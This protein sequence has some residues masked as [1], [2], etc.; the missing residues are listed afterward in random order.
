MKKRTEKQSGKPRV[1]TVFFPRGWWKDREG[2]Q[3]VEILLR[4]RDQRLGHGLYQGEE[5]ELRWHIDEIQ[6]KGGLEK[7]LL[8]STRTQCKR[9]EQAHFSVLAWVLRVKRK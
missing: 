7:D 6:D 8:S 9:T 3:E 2:M 5:L 4:L 1:D